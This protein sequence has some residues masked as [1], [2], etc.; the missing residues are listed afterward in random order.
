MCLLRGNELA[1]EEGEEALES[2]VRA[3]GRATAPCCRPRRGPFSLHRLQLQ[4]YPPSPRRHSMAP[5]PWKG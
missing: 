3:R 4:L 5:P 2:V 1:S